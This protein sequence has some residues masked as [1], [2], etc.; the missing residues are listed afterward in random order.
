[1]SLGRSLGRCNGEGGLKKERMFDLSPD[2]LD[3]LDSSILQGLVGVAKCH[4]KPYCF[5]SQNRQL[6]LLQMYHSWN[7]SRRTLNRRLKKL[8]DAGYI[9]RVRRH[10]RAAD[11]HLI[12]RSTLYK[13]CGKL[14]AWIG[15]VGRWVGRICRVFAVPG[16]AQYN[17]QRES[18]VF[19][20]PP[21]SVE[22][23][24]KSSIKGRASPIKSIL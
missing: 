21:H 5:V 6:E 10:R 18:E 22:Y 13:L 2:R 4:N 12:L 3:G 11:G 1:M 15:R 23:L 14:F 7:T 24:W 20:E 9:E 16:M 8:E 17:S 19:L